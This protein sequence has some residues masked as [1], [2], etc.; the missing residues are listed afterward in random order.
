MIN[1]YRD[2]RDGTN[3]VLT[4][5]QDLWH[6][7]TRITRELRREHPQ[8]GNAMYD[9]KQVITRLIK[10]EYASADELITAMTEYRHKYTTAHEYSVISNMHTI[11]T[12]GAALPNVDPTK[13]LTG[14]ESV[15]LYNCDNPND[16]DESNNLQHPVLRQAGVVALINLIK[17]QHIDFIMNRI[18]HECVT[19]KGTT[20][21]EAL[22]RIFNLRL[23]AFGG[24]RTFTTAQQFIIIIM[25]EYNYQRINKSTNQY[26]CDVKPLSL[27]RTRIEYIRPLPDD[28]NPIL[29][30]L[31]AEFHSYTTEWTDKELT[32]LQQYCIQLATGVEHCHTKNVFQW[33]QQHAE[34][35][36]KTV[37]QVKRK[38]NELYGQQ[39]SQP[40]QPPQ[41]L[42]QFNAVQCNATITS[43][44]H[45][46]QSMDI[47]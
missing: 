37:S 47:A 35:S 34:L 28:A 23:T 43:D 38:I 21:N 33:I 5:L 8:Y 30:R 36:L 12:I 4:V 19:T 6:A 42:Q 1:A 18:K 17:P 46:H 26:Y 39:Q 15:A 31:Q 44:L 16:V 40:P 27:H 2:T 11:S 41:S 29:Y 22:H 45:Q 32:A 14:D 13:V 3:I 10:C 20:P 24:I 9:N 25:Y 7:R